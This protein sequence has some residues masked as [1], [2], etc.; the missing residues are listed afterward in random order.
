MAAEG[1]Q[2][3]GRRTES[4]RAG[5]TREALADLLE[6]I[7]TVRELKDYFKTRDTNITRQVISYKYLWTLFSPATRVVAS[8]F[9]GIRQLF[10]VEEIEE[11]KATRHNP[12]SYWQVTCIYLDFD[13]SFSRRMVNFKVKSFE[14][15]KPIKALECYPTKFMDHEVEFLKVCEEQGSKFKSFCFG[16]KG[17]AKLFFYEGNATSSGIGLNQAQRPLRRRPSVMIS[18]ISPVISGRSPHKHSADSLQSE[19]IFRR[20]LFDDP[21][22]LIGTPQGFDSQSR[23]MINV[24]HAPPAPS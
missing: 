9:M 4:E 8:P 13:T 22:S 17:A 18:T 15:T 5:E 21:P 11:I 6:C 12:E 2:I 10:L 1:S 24:S 23:T 19:S 14:D 20:L 3:P 16:L 7:R